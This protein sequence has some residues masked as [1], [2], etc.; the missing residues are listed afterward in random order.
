MKATSKKPAPTKAAV[1][2]KEASK[3][4]PLPKIVKNDEWLV[5][6]QEAIVGRHQHALTKIEELTQSQHELAVVCNGFTTS[7]GLHRSGKH[8]YSG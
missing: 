3:K 4:M 5:P 6:Y 8:G 2:K 1:S 7:F